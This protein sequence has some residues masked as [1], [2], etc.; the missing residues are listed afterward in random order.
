M[1]WLCCVLYLVTQWYPTLCD[2]K[3]CRLPGSSV[4]RILQ[5]RVLGWVAMPS[6]R[7]S[8]QPRSPTLQVDSLT[9]EPPGEALLVM[10]AECKEFTLAYLGNEIYVW[11][12]LNSLLKL[13]EIRLKYIFSQMCS[14]ELWMLMCISNISVLSTQKR[15]DFRI[16]NCIVLECEKTENCLKAECDLDEILIWGELLIIYFWGIY[17]LLIQRDFSSLFFKCF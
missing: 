2:P 11:E 12:I 3:D 8:S 14:K 16:W 7:G 13:A 9:S 6:S 10:A 5:A 15:V 1:E 17:C 4:H